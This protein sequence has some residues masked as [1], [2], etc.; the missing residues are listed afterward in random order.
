MY[1]KKKILSELVRRIEKGGAVM[2]TSSILT[3]VVIKD[4]KRV[5]ALANALEAS[6]RD[7]KRKPSAPTIP[8]LT[9]V[10][11][12]QKFFVQKQWAIMQ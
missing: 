11:A 4:S 3:N 12:V 5:E 7:P 9:D 10:E 2:A 6:S 8:V 1:N